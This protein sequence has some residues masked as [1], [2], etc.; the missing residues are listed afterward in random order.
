MKKQIFLLLILVFLLNL[1]WEVSHSYLYDWNKFPLEND[2]Y[3][4]IPRI[5]GASLGDLGWII[6]IFSI[7]SLSNKNLRWIKNPSKKDY[8]FVVMLGLFIAI[9]IELKAQ[10]LDKWSYTDAMPTI[11]G[12]GISPLLQLGATSLLALWLIRK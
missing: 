12:I 2:V 8:I 7:I 11:F 4:Y 9:G 6:F 1:V 5:F 10:L 3:Y